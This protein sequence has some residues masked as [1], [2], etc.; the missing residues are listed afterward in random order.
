MV[1]TSKAQKQFYFDDAAKH[2]FY[3]YPIVSKHL[4]LYIGHA[5]S[6]E[7]CL[8]PA[9]QMAGWKSPSPRLLSTAKVDCI[10]LKISYSS[11]VGWAKA[12]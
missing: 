12:I 5:T 10:E 11:W 8:L 2:D 6:N 1:T 9:N 3:I 7:T 4:L